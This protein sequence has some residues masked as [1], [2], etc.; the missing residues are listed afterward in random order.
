MRLKSFVD[1]F[2]LKYSEFG[3]GRNPGFAGFNSFEEVFTVSVSTK[4]LFGSEGL[5]GNEGSWFLGILIPV[6]SEAAWSFSGYLNEVNDLRS[7]DF[8]C[9]GLDSEDSNNFNLGHKDMF[10]II[11]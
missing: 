8:N 2:R 11:N 10:G 3:R 6:V 9:F 5:K 4:G 7:G 1:I